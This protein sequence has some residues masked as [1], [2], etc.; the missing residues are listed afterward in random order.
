M[1]GWLGILTLKIL[2]ATRVMKNTSTIKNRYIRVST[3][4]CTSVRHTRPCQCASP[5]GVR[6][7]F[8]N[9]GIHPRVG[10]STNMIRKTKRDAKR[11]SIKPCA[12]KMDKQIRS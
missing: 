4:F 12:L 6:C 5:R 11:P 7:H 10:G 3:D 1:G 8:Q 2:P 9:V